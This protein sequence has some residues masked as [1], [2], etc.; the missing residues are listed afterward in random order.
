MPGKV[1]IS[2]SHKDEDWKDRVRKHLDV[3]SSQG[4]FEIW[5]DRRIGGGED[6]YEAIVNAIEAGSVAVLLVSAN[7]LASDFIMKEEAPRLLALLNSG[8]LRRLIP[9]VIK[10]C[11]WETVDWL[12]KK[13]LR[14]EDGT[15]LSTM[16]DGAADK[17]MA[18][19]ALEI[20]R[21]M[22]S[23]IVP[24]SWEKQGGRGG[25]ELLDFL[26]CD[27]APQQHAFNSRFTGWFQTERGLPQFHIV[28]G[29][30]EDRPGSLVKRLGR[31][32][33]DI[34]VAWLKKHKHL[35]TEAAPLFKDV[36]W[37][38][39]TV[40]DRLGL[41]PQ[42]EELIDNLFETFSD[43]ERCSFWPEQK[44]PEKFADLCSDPV[45]AISH[46]ITTW[47]APT[48]ALA[49]RYQTFWRQVRDELQK[50]PVPPQFLILLHVQYPPEQKK[51]FS[52]LM[53]RKTDRGE[54]VIQALKK[55]SKE[56]IDAGFQAQVLSE[57]TEVTEGDVTQW[58]QECRYTERDR[59]FRKRIE[60]FYGDRKQRP[61]SEVEEWLEE[62]CRELNEGDG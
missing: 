14:P 34:A 53:P 21:L 38:A 32:E 5:D 17:A 1:F 37:P 52:K 43:G 24:Q 6:W 30:K 41:M 33:L 46:E 28:H 7:S 58:A 57:L 8:K 22:K 35:E 54:R 61:M 12:R 23:A 40:V 48:E 29:R 26:K 25:N 3:P 45:I 31:I 56:L 27:R 36:A 18:A 20:S 50:R 4:H 59:K 55:F 10:P 9:L 42:Y 47:D 51:W 15:A 62:C 2:Y 60:S 44:W 49:I 16:S 39:T 13:N 19:L 11:S